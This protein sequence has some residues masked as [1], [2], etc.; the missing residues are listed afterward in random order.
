MPTKAKILSVL[1]QIARFYGIP[2][3]NITVYFYDGKYDGFELSTPKNLQKKMI[4]DM[5]DD[6][7]S[8]MIEATESFEENA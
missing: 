3:D 8:E 2:P 4:D 5:L 6:I 1:Y 7:I